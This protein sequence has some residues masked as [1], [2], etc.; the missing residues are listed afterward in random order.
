MHDQAKVLAKSPMGEALLWTCGY[1]YELKG[2]QAL[3]GV[4]GFQAS[5]RQSAHTKAAQFRVIGAG[6]RTLQA[7]RGSGRK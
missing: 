4:E 5:M 3:G 1:V 6:V 7:A 2:L